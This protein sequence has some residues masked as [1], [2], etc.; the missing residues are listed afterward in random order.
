MVNVAFVR[1]ELLA[2]WKEYYLIRDVLAGEMRVKGMRETHL[3]MPNGHDRSQENKERY[4]SYLK[5]AVFYN[6]ARRT[7]QGYVGQVFGEKPVVQMPPAMDIIG[8]DVTG[9]GIPLDQ[10][11]KKV[12]SETIA[13]S[14]CG[15]L[16]DYPYQ[17]QNAEDDKA[18]TMAQA[19]M[20]RVQPVVQVFSP[21][22]LVNWREACIGGVDQIVFVVILE[23]FP[24][25]DDG[26]EMKFSRQWRIC[27]LD[28]NGHYIQEIY[29]LSTPMQVDSAEYNIYSK[30]E[31][32]KT[33]DGNSQYVLF[34]SYNML[35]FNGQPMT[36]IPFKFIGAMN[37]D[38]H[39]DLP[40]FYDL[41]SINIAH[42]RNSAD[43]EE[44]CYMVGQPTPVLTGLT[45]EW[46]K[47]VLQ[48]KINFG[49]RGG[50][51]LP[52][53]GNAFLIQAQANTMLKEAMQT[54]EDQ[55]VKLGA[56]LI[57]PSNIMRTATEVAIE[58]AAENCGLATITSNV[59]DGI[60]WALQECAT[61][62]GLDATSISYELNQ[63]FDAAIMTP[64]DQAALIAQWQTGAISFTEMRS[65]MRMSGLPLLDDDVAKAEI[66]ADR[67]IAPLPPIGAP[68][69]IQP[70]NIRDGK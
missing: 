33:K 61:W 45:E 57:T 35:D 22:A 31:M 27:R 52:A 59:S 49:S 6:V 55:M 4:E 17:R 54:K 16:V 44:S 58:S 32:N 70:E 20:Q 34:G 13:Y 38:S 63:H 42:Y 46:I 11:A 2:L 18:V 50:I 26:F 62:M 5:R 60:T 56:K 9:S 23:L 47:T 10:F 67:P 14:R 15:L 64:A 51:M 8:K 29:R 30:D 41:C 19:A 40:A 12:L 28:E 65:A 37:N 53:G 24:F 21:M 7:L 68:N 1:P 66:D 48:N 36:H 39:P 3:P 25:E 69:T 43:Y